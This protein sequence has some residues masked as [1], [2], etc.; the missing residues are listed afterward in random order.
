MDVSKDIKITLN[1]E[2]CKA[3]Q[4]ITE[5][6]NSFYREELCDKMP[7]RECPLAMFCSNSSY[8]SIITFEET[9]NDIANME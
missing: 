1:D 8:C 2:E 9:L 3:V 5:I 4:K 6:V 7:C